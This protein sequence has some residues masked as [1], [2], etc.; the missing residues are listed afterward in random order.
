MK[1]NLLRERLLV[2]SAV[3]TVIAT[4]LSVALAVFADEGIEIGVISTL[5][6]LLLTLGFSAFVMLRLQLED[7]DERRIASLPLQRLPS[8]PEIELAIVNIVTRVSGF[9]GFEGDRAIGTVGCA[10]VRRFGGLG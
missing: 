7:I 10:G 6:T 1:R 3:V 8:V 9:R 2:V 4:G 5:T